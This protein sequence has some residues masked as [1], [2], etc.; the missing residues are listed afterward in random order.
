[1][2]MMTFYNKNRNKENTEKLANALSSN[3]RQ[4]NFNYGGVSPLQ[5]GVQK[6]EDLSEGA[7]GFFKGASGLVRGLKDSG[8]FNKGASSA[9]TSSIGNGLASGAS[10]MSLGSAENL[11]FKGFG[12]G[13]GGGAPWGAIGGAAKTG[14]NG[15]MGKDDSEYSDLEQSTIYPLQG[16]SM[17]SSFGPWGALGG[18]LYGLGYS[19]KD[20]LGLEDNDWAT[21]L[22]FPIGMGDEHQGLISL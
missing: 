6:N 3:N 7:T 15:I 16:A 17:G 10:D 5:G 13:N 18:A 2:A 8:L 14:Y 4:D 12:S 1:M 11:S 22:I 19:L 20:N 9:A 21:T